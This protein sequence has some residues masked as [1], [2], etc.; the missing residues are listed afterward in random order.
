MSQELAGMFVVVAAPKPGQS[1][2]AVL[3]AIDEEIARLAKEPPTEAELT[4]AKNRTES[5]MIFGL[6]PLGGFGGRAATLNTYYLLTGDPGF[7]PKDLARYR[8]VTAGHVRDAAA[9]YL[10]KDARVV[11]TVMPKR[12]GEGEPPPPGMPLPPQS[13]GAPTAGPA[14]SALGGSR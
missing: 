12:P 4:R 14:T 10:R 6:E 8:G 3:A 9:K 13:P 1:P 2:E 7:L 5:A 11:L